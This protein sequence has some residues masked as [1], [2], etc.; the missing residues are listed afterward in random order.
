MHARQRAV[1]ADWM[2]WPLVGPMADQVA[3]QLLAA[4][5]VELGSRMAVWNGARARFSEDWF[6]ASGCDR[7][8]LLGAGLDSYAWRQ[9]TAPV[10]EVDHPATQAWK[11]GRLEML[12]LDAP[13][14]LTW[15]PV[16]FEKD[17]L[18]EALDAHGLTDGKSFFTWIGVTEYISSA[19]VESTLAALPA[20]TLAMSYG[21]PEPLWADDARAASRGFLE[22]AAGSGEPIRTLMAPEDVA[23]LLA[24]HGFEV[25]ED[26]GP[27]DVESRYG[28][29]AT[30]VLSERVVLARKA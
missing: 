24:Q 15:V 22:M 11:R 13:G 5:G 12:A 29:P 8:V 16:D 19:A 30:F 10:F 23:R 27:A 28:V 7:Y 4:F 14:H 2:A 9:D 20:G 18:R 6:A 1:L 26:V 25:L 3:Q 21:V 17:S